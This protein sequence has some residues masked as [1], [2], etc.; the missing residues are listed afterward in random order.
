L[1]STDARR[2][3]TVSTL[4]LR[5]RASHLS[6]RRDERGGR[7]V[8]V[9]AGEL[10]LASRPLLDDFVAVAVDDGAR[11]LVLDVERLEFID[12]TGLQAILSARELCAQRTCTF[13]LVGADGQVL[14]LFE[15]AGVLDELPLRRTAPAQAA[16]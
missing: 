5:G 12:S 4:R 7:H 16:S 11:S 13:E 9:L 2:S 15:L 6:V 8:L 10:D 1:S 3:A 14:R